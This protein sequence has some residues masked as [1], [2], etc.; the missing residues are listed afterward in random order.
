MTLFNLLESIR[1]VV[2][3]RKHQHWPDLTTFSVHFHVEGNSTSEGER[4]FQTYEVTG[5]SPQS[6]T[7]AHE[8]NGF[9]SKGTL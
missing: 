6:K 2:A 9:A 7:F 4:S 5:I 1:V 3:I 8:L